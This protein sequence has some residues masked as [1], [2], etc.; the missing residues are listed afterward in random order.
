MLVQF[1]V[2]IEERILEKVKKISKLR[3]E[4]HSDFV[5]GSVSERLANLG[6]LTKEECKALGVT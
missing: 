1:N 2:K 5:R 6:Y 4:H 3:G